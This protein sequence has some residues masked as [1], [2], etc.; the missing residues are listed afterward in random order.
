MS[1]VKILYPVVKLGLH[2]TVR[3]IGIDC[4]QGI[5]KSITLLIRS[6]REERC[7]VTFAGLLT[8]SGYTFIRGGLALGR[9]LVTFAGLC[10][11]INRLGSHASLIVLQS[12]NQLLLGHVVRDLE[13][14]R[15][16]G[17]LGI[18]QNF[19][20]LFLVQLGF[21]SFLGR[22]LLKTKAELLAHLG[23]GLAKLCSV[24]VELHG[25]NMS[26]RETG[27]NML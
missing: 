10:I 25:L 2:G 23:H 9:L 11:A 26:I 1:V 3:V 6:R 14:N 13:V 8:I 7:K 15:I 22:C 19:I 27:L 4:G 16:S 18:C 21:P 12:R 24:Q 5:T 17:H 20:D